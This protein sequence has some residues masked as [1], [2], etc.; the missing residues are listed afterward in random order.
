MTFEHINETARNI[1]NDILERKV[2]LPI[3]D[4]DGTL[5][6][7]DDAYDID[8]SPKFLPV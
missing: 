3:K 1:Y 4:K 8:L 7:L 6:A 5:I 2:F